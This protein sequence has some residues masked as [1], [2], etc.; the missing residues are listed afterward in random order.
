MDQVLTQSELLGARDR[1]RRRRTRFPKKIIKRVSTG[2]SVEKRFNIT[3]RYTLF[4][5]GDIVQRYH[6]DCLI[7][8]NI[9]IIDREIDNVHCIYKSIEGSLL[10][11]VLE[12]RGT[13]RDFLRNFYLT[14]VQA[15]VPNK[16]V[17]L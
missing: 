4:F 6:E 13:E 7:L 11:G 15:S 5:P 9:I 3:L 14:I 1:V 17:I 10:I 8:I 12:S 2:L 16:H